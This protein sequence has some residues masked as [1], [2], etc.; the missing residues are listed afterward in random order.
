MKYLA[1][2][3]VLLVACQPSG[4]TDQ[5]ETSEPAK[6][7]ITSFFG[8]ELPPKK[9]D[10]TT[11][12]LL[13]KNLAEAKANLD[14][15]PDSVDLII[16]YGRRAAYLGRY[17]EAI[18]IYTDGLA[19]Y[20]DSYRL[21]R[22]R[23]HRYISTRQLDKALA[24][25]ENAAFK[26]T[27][28]PNQ[29]EPDGQPN[30]LNQP[31]G[32]DKFNIW[33]HFGLAEYLSGRFDKAVSAYKKCME[34]SNN[35]DL[36]AATSY[37]LYMASRRVGNDELASATIAEI[38][39]DME[40]IENDAY[41]DLLLLFKGLKTEDELLQSATLEDGSLDP[42]RAYGIGNW[43]LQ[44]NRIDDARNIFWKVMESPSWDAF[45]FIATEAELKNMATSGG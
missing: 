3:L 33:Y 34:Y 27:S 42:T 8:D 31:L 26:S 24:D 23:G 22:H 12:V 30:R 5:Q 32:N 21:L 18:D 11:R 28:A 4:N 43:Y 9:I 25:Y 45:G 13:E 6:A 41:R 35:N 7:V 2:L 1:I 29:I 17:L 10:S 38:Q 44:N 19:K 14:A 15:N 16:W 20:P 39:E 40:V 36:K 37:W